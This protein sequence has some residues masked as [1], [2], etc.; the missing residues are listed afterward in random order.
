MN[1]QQKILDLR[2]QGYTVDLVRIELADIAPSLGTVVMTDADTPELQDWR[3]CYG[4]MVMVSGIDSTRIARVA[5]ALKPIAKRVITNLYRW[6]I[7]NNRGHLTL[8]LLQITDTE[9]LL[10]WQA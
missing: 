10:T 1:G 5:D 9:G 4:L 7:R 2:R 3:F 6:P 8:E